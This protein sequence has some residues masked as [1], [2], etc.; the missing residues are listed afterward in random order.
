MVPIQ[1]HNNKTNTYQA[2]AYSVV[3]YD[4]GTL[5]FGN[6][7][8]ISLLVQNC[9]IALILGILIFFFLYKMIE[10][11][12]ASLNKQ[13]SSALKDDSLSVQTDYDFTPLQNLTSNINSALSRISAAQALNQQTVTYD[14][15]TEMNH[16]IEM[17]GYPTLGIDMESLKIQGAS[18]N[19]E[20][21]TGVSTE[22]ILNCNVQDIDDQALKLNI[23]NLLDRV[24]QHPHEIAS[25]SLEF[26]GIE[27]Q[28]S[29]KGIY[30]KEELAY[31]LISFIPINQEQ[32]EAV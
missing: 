13:L 20:E 5:T 14:R 4:T 29:A 24:Q 11:P 32:E 28:L 7:R 19:F 22:R 2:E 15:L 1:F 3:V 17:I 30:G 10:F 25:D 6:K 27:F 8:T 12:I 31:T 9:L 26:S 21:E 23:S 18:A 16:M